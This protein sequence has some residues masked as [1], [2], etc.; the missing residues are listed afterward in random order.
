[1]NEPPPICERL[2]LVRKANK[3]SSVRA[4]WRSLGGREGSGTSY[5]SA[6]F[7]HR[8]REPSVRYL[9]RVKDVYGVSLEWLATGKGAGP[10]CSHEFAC[11][12]CGEPPPK[13]VM[14]EFFPGMFK[15]TKGEQQ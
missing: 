1:M 7:Y 2:E 6:R 5:E 13:P 11:V 10:S 8:D 4:F 12:H 15:N 9:V 3:V 14:R